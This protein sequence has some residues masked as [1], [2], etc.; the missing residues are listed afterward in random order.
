MKVKLLKRLR[1]QVENEINIH[2]IIKQG[3]ITVGMSYGYDEDYYRGLFELGGTE[4]DVKSKAFKIFLSNN[5]EN[6]RQRYKKYSV[7]F[8]GK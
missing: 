4:A 1:R 6:I 2:S 3:G 7:R 8:K 5:I